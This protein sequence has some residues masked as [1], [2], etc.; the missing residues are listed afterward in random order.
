MT[1]IYE[2][3]GCTFAMYK[4]QIRTLSV[5]CIF[6]S[7]LYIGVSPVNYTVKNRLQRRDGIDKKRNYAGPI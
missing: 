6:T 3:C 1:F 5:V 4:V 7:I 2:R